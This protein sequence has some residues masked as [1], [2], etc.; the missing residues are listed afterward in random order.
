MD[1]LLKATGD[2][3]RMK[4]SEGRY[5]LLLGKFFWT[6][7]SKGIICLHMSKFDI[8]KVVGFCELYMFLS[9]VSFFV[10]LPND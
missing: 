4:E 7:N 3:R 2:N 6:L 5:C 1:H 8:P 10:T 9:V